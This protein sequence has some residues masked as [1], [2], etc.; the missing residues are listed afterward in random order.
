MDSARR[1]V[2]LGLGTGAIIAATG[3]ANANIIGTVIIDGQRYAMIHDESKC[4]GCEA[5]VDACKETNNVPDGVTRLEIIRTKVGDSPDAEYSFFRKSCQHCESPSCV[6]VC[7]TGASFIDTKTGIV[8]VNP[9]RC[10]GCLYCVAACPY[11]VRYLDPVTK[12]VDKCDFCRKTKLAKNEL[13]ACV[14]ACP[15]DALIFG[16]LNDM[17]SDIRAQ[18]NQKP[19]YKYKEYLGTKPKMF[20]IASNKR[21]VVS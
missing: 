21:G 1:K 14:Q 12:S 16:D 11:K 3:I 5:C 19:T 10:V 18:L 17:S 9:D 7:P 2:L 13:P 8:D 15:K 20:R 4:I 6:Q